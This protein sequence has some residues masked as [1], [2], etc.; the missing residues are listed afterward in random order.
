MEVE[1]ENG[2]KSLFFMGVFVYAQLSAIVIYFINSQRKCK[3]ND[4]QIKLAPTI[5]VWNMQ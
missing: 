2:Y 1:S 4:T 3:T 5:S